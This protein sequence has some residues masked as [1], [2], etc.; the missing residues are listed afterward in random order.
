MLCTDV[1]SFKIATL[2]GHHVTSIAAPM[3]AEA[4]IAASRESSKQCADVSADIE[5]T[6]ESLRGTIER[7]QATSEK[8]KDVMSATAD[9]ESKWAAFKAKFDEGITALIDKIGKQLE[10]ESAEKQVER[11]D[12]PADLERKARAL[13]RAIRDAKGSVIVFTEK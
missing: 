11:W 13:A 4:T 9:F 5:K 10:H 1:E 6:R 3:P 12:K 7:L 2:T 8:S